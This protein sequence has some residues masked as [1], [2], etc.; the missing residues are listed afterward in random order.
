MCKRLVTMINNVGNLAKVFN[1][2]NGFLL[3]QEVQAITY[4]A[5]LF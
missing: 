1:V 5:A 2:L 4:M 3:K